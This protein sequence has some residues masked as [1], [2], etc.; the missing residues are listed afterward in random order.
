MVKHVK[1]EASTAPRAREF[2]GKAQRQLLAALRARTTADA[3]RI[4]SLVDLRQVG[5][6]I[7]LSKGTARS[8]VDALTTSPYMRPTLGG[9]R[10]TD[11]RVEG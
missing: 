6:E 9:Y 1:E 11:G 8:A 10:F 7:G 4:W 2:R 5:R 3:E